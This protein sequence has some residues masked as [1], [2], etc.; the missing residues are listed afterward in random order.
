M[1]IVSFLT[2]TPDYKKISGLT[3]GTTTAEHRAETQK[4]WSKGDV[5][6]SVALLLLIFTAY[7]YFTG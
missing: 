5:I 2:E 6:A 3:Y 4:S 7:M 1:I